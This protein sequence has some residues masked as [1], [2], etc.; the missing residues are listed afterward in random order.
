[1]KKYEAN[2]E[3]ENI[4]LKKGFIETTSQRDKKK[5]KKSFK[6]SKNAKKEI[7]FDYINIHILNS[8]HGQDSE[9]KITE[10]QLKSILLYFKLNSTDFKEINQNGKFDFK[11]TEEGLT[12]MKD[13]L[14]DLIKFDLHKP[15][16]NKLTRILKEYE[17][18]TLD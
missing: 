16:R 17:D 11:K 5:G 7:Y 14:Q 18:I 4:L 12:S 1:M 10:S 15:R 9:I 8:I 13:E 3:L 2:E 6:L